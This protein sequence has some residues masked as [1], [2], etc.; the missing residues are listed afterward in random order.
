MIH[1]IGKHSRLSSLGDGKQR[2]VSST[3][4]K[5]LAEVNSLSQPDP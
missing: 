5:L 4:E 2:E 1:V 3:Q